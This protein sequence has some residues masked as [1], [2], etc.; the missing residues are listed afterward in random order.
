[1]MKRLTALIIGAFLAML[2]AAPALA[3]N[4]VIY[5]NSVIEISDIDEDWDPGGTYK[6]ISITF[7]PGGSDD[8]M[9]IKKG[10]GTAATFFYALSTDGEP[11]V[12]YY[13]KE[14]LNP[15]LDFGDCTLTGGAK[16]IL[17]IDR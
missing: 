3:A 7:V 8:V 16:V 17:V 2:F 4:T 10:S 13:F 6:I 14:A 9:V 5:D 1:M 15:F 11:R 12:A